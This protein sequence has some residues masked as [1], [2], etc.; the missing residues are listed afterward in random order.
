VLIIQIFCTFFG[1]QDEQ[2]VKK[3]ISEKNNFSELPQ[4]SPDEEQQIKEKICSLV[5]ETIQS[6]F[7]SEV[8]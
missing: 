5:N 4:M 3:F 2:E 6:R 7:N 1:S 8:P